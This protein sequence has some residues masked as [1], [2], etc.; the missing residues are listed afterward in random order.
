MQVESD[1]DENQHLNEINQSEQ[2]LLRSS[3]GPPPDVTFVR[4][5]STQLSNSKYNQLTQ[6]HRNNKELLSHE[7][8]ENQP[9]LS[10]MGSQPSDDYVH[11]SFNHFPDDPEFSDLVQQA[12]IAIENNILPQIIYQGSSG[13]YFV[14]NTNLVA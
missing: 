8:S 10:Q 14:K 4:G 5:S 6:S 3:Y 12:E 7:H 1:D 2:S 13:S 11:F 9:L